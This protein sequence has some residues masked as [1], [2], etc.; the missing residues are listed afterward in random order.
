MKKVLTKGYVGDVVSNLSL[1]TQG[2]F[3]ER[4]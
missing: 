1:M 4:C 2:L 3:I